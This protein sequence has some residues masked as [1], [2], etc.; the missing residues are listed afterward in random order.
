ML[1]GIKA[2]LPRYEIDSSSDAGKK[3]ENVQGGI[4]FENVKFHYP[5]RPGH[6]ILDG[7]SID[8]PAGKTIAFVG[9]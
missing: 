9:T 6:T 4:S 3:P 2:I 1:F 5:T 8:I 7:L